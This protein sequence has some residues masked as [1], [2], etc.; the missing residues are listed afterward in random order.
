MLCC[1]VLLG[2]VVVFCCGVLIYDVLFCLALCCVVLCCV[3][4]CDGSSKV[5]CVALFVVCC[6]GL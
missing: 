5:F 4:L 6:V 3:A 2:V 1:L